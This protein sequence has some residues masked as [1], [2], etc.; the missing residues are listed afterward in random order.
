MASSAEKPMQLFR[1]ALRE[2]DW[3]LAA[4]LARALER[5]G[6]AHPQ[7]ELELR[8]TRGAGAPAQPSL[9]ALRALGALAAELELEESN[10]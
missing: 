4:L 10:G 6:G 2:R 7:L 8:Q 3:V 5:E 1:F 9:A